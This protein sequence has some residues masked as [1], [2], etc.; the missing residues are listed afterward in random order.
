MSGEAGDEE[1]FL[2]ASPFLDLDFACA[3]GRQGGV[4]FQEYYLEQGFSLCESR[5]TVFVV[6]G[7]ALL[8]VFRNAGV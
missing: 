7:E 1:V 4:F 3:G 6:V 5:A 8:R 2:F